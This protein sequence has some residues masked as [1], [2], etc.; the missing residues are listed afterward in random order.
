MIS[1]ETLWLI[2]ARKDEESPWIDTGT[3][4]SDAVAVLRVYDYHEEHTPDQEQRLVRTTVVNTLEDPEELREHLR[5]A[6]AE[7]ETEDLQFD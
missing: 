1:A 4:K 7:K 2:Q 5:R 3:H 6:A